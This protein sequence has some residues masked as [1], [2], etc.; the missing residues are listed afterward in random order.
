[1]LKCFDFETGRLEFAKF[2]YAYTLD[3]VV[4]APLVPQL[5]SYGSKPKYST[6]AAGRGQP[7]ANHLLER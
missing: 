2:A 3:R 6:E 7:A 1:M 4:C 5:H